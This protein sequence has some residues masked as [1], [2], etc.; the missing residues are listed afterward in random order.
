MP[1]LSHGRA[2]GSSGPWAENVHPGLAGR[3]LLLGTPGGICKD[4]IILLSLPLK[5]LEC[6]KPTLTS[7]RVWG[8][9]REV[10]EGIH[11]AAGSSGAI[12]AG[13]GTTP[14]RRVK[15]GS[16]NDQQFLIKK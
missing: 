8:K 3:A 9:Q 11:G 10:D 7:R 5:A 13:A 12:T 4:P 16:S 2:Q 6:L 14:D 1:S 15:R